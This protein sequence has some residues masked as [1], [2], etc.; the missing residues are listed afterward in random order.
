MM[1]FWQPQKDWG[2]FKELFF[3]ELTD[4]LV[5]EDLNSEVMILK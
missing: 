3:K 2:F 1:Y 4:D 5:S